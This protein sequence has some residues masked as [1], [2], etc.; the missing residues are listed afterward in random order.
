MMHIMLSRI[1]TRE[2]AVHTVLAALVAE[3][4]A[5]QRI[6]L[7]ALICVCSICSPK[8]GCCSR[9]RTLALSQVS[10]TSELHCWPE[11]EMRAGVHM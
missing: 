2:F 7:S 8:T 5:A 3:Q 1:L 11:V 4:H 9:T 6:A 10:N